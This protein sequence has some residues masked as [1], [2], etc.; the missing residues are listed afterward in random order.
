MTLTK[1][2][3]IPILITVM[4]IAAGFVCFQSGIFS[5][6]EQMRVF[7]KQAGFLAPAAFIALQIL[8]VVIPIIPGAVSCVIGVMIFGPVYGFIYN[9]VGVVAGSIIIFLLVRK[10]GR[11]L[12]LKLVK[13]ETYTK[14]VSWIEK[15]RKFD[16]MFAAAIL[17]PGMP[18]DLLCMLAGLTP[19]SV[20]KFSAILLLGK[21]LSLAA[22]SLGISSIMQW[23][24]TVI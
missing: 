12:I 11:P 16:F 13:E 14:Y 3:Y 6:E 9:Y 10:Y 24:Q 17:L 18:D 19:M 20:K 1:K 15:G 2:N 4:L 22:Y 5:S 7:L 8:Q 23:I 21:P